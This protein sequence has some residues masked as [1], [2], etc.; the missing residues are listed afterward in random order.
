[1]VDRS[2]TIKSPSLK[3]LGYKGVE[4]L[5]LGNKFGFIF[6]VSPLEGENVVN[7]FIASIY[8]FS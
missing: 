5:F 2:Q 4:H 8:V 1:M 7:Y 6:K 3:V